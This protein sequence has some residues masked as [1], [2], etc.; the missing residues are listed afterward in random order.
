MCCLAHRGSAG[1]FLSLQIMQIFIKVVWHP[2]ISS[3]RVAYCLC[4]S[5]F[6]IH[7]GTYHNLFVYLDNPFIT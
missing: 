1:V 5:S 7:H 3:R 6:L 4:Q 2:G